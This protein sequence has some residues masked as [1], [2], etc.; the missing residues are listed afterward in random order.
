MICN[1]IF[2]DILKMKSQIKSPYFNVILK[3][4]KSSKN[5]LKSDFVKLSIKLLNTLS[6]LYLP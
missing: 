1:L 3:I 5:Y 2:M 6:G 4:S